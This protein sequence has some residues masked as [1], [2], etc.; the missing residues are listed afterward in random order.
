MSKE[1]LY[2]PWRMNYVTSTQ[3]TMDDCVFCTKLTADSAYDRENLVLYR[4]KTAFVV[5]NIYPYN[6]GHLMVLPNRH[7]SDL[8]A[9]PQETQF[10]IMALITHFAG[11]LAELMQPDGLNI[12]INIGRAAG[13]GIDNHLHV[14]LV[15]RWNGDGNFM[16]VV[17]NTRVLP[18][19]LEDTYDRIMALLKANPPAI[20]INQTCQEE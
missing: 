2:T 17:G 3:K 15:P 19:A 7:V 16:S 20:E 6:T 4:G 5:M 18:E 12:G 13:A 1:I 11:L 9:L 10:E 14:H 8:T